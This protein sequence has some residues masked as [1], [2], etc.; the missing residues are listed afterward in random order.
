MTS[1]EKV[2]NAT[3]IENTEGKPSLGSIE[4]ERARLLS[5]LPDPDIG[6]SDEERRAIVGTL[7]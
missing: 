6:K 1:I 2:I 4:F 7:S 5:N 3:E